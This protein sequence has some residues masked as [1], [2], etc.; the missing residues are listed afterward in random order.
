M[1]GNCQKRPE[2]AKN[3]RKLPKTA[4]NCQKRPEI[5]SQPPFNLPLYK[6]FLC[7]IPEGISENYRLIRIA[8]NCQKK[9]GNHQ[10]P[11]ILVHNLTGLTSNF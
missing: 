11:I 5:T 10:K 3:C 2:I 9:P 1:A 4:R 6:H 7:Y 8:K